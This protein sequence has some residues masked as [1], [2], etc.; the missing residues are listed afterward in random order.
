MATKKKLLQAAAGSAGGGA[1]LNVEEVFSTYVY[2]G[3]GAA[4]TI[5]NGID[6]DGEGGLVWIKCRNAAENHNLYDTERGSPKFLESNTTDAENSGGASGFNGF[7]SDGFSLA[8]NDSDTNNSNNDYA[9]WT[10]R[11]APKFFDVVTWTG[12]G[13][14]PRNISHNLGS[15]PGCFIVK[16]TSGTTDWRVYHRGLSSPEL[17]NL[18]L[19]N[20]NAVS[21]T[22]H[23]ANTAPTDTHFTVSN[24]ANVNAS[25]SEYVAY[26]FAHNDGDASFGPDGDADIIKCGSYTGNDGTQDIDLGFEPAW[27]LVKSSSNTRDWKIIDNMRGFAASPNN[28][29]LTPNSSNSEENINASASTIEP[30]AT[31]FR[32]T[33][34][35][36]ETNSLGWSYIYIAIRRGPMAVPESATDVFAMDTLGGTLPNPPAFN[37]G[38]T[39]DAGLYKVINS[40]SSWSLSSRLTQGKRLSTDSTAAEASESAQTFDFMDGY[41]NATSVSTNYQSWMWKRAPNYFDVVAYTGN[42]TAGRTVS[43][44]LGVAPEMMWVKVRSQSYGWITYHESLGNTKYMTLDDTTAAATYSQNWNNTDPTA[45]EFTLGTNWN[46]NKSGETF[47]AYLFASLDG[48]SKVGTFTHTDG[49][50]TDVDCGFTSGARFVIW[51]KTSNIGQWVV[52]DTERGIVAGNDPYLEL[53][54]TNAESSAYDIIDPLSSGFTVGSV[55]SSGTYIFY[56]IA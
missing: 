35:D 25:G 14:N 31:G 54:S 36:A 23:W 3:T 29:W 2:E 8:T 12:D 24:H 9:S 11:K 33:A 30:T 15:V 52:V 21:G 53:N 19:H 56:A 20:T 40:S 41:Y 48:V 43:H 37:S 38:F 5:T 7:N 49:T 1:G 44:N 22:S 47:I 55:M 27:V 45:T 50:P 18:F 13:T 16:C 17:N 32:L 39:V 26:L 4:Q 10:F 42:G 51:K 34:G 6:L 28:K 46:V